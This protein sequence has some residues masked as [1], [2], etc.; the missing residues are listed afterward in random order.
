LNYF[1][2]LDFNT[3]KTL[4]VWGAGNKGKTIAKYLIEKDI[5]FE[6][7]CDNPNKIGHD[8]YGKILKPVT[9]LEQVESTQ[10]IITVANKTAQIEILDYLKKLNKK[11]IEDY[12]FFC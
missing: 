12:V 4:V 7:I 2:E 10:S 5:T 9:F 3:N 11:N 1:L 8:I 6:W